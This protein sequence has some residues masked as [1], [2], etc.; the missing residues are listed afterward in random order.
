MLYLQIVETI[1]LSSS[2]LV[3][4]VLFFSLHKILVTVIFVKLIPH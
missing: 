1:N 2:S 4:C 3:V